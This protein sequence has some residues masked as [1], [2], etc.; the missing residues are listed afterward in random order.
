[1]SG[2]VFLDFR[3]AFDL[4]HHDILLKKEEERTTHVQ[5]KHRK[6]NFLTTLLTGSS[7]MR[8]CKWHILPR[9][10]Y[11]KWS[12]SRVDLRPIYLLMTAPLI[13]LMTTQIIYIGIYNKVYVSGWYCR[14]RMALTPTKTKCILMETRQ[15]HQKKKLSL[16]Q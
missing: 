9:N 14:N 1:M 4:V 3:E 2:A 12:G 13:Q 10:V 6:Y 16:N 8:T 11:N 7:T 15:K 5:L